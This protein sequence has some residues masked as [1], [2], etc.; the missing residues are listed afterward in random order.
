MNK[1]VSFKAIID[2]KTFDFFSKSVH[3]A[4]LKDGQFSRAYVRKIYVGK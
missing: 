4:L 3:V 1:K 2:C